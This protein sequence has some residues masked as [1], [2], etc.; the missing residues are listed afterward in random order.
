V[1]FAAIL[2]LL[3]SGALLGQSTG[4]QYLED[5]KILSSPEME[6]RGDGTMGLTRAAQ[7]IEKRYRKL[8]LEPAGSNGYLQ[9]FTV[10]TGARLKS[11]NALH[12]Q[13][14]AART[15]LKLEQDF[16]PFSFSS[17]GSVTAPVVFAGYGA[18][19]QEFG[20]DDYDKTEVKD[21]IVVL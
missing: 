9:P 11:D 1:A 18:S 17:S 13:N 15:S 21:K 6:G 8:G 7:L 5:I 2:A 14:G 4:Q 3:L 16:V 19:A 12:V 20:Y 10:I